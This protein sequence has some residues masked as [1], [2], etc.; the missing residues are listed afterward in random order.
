MYMFNPQISNN[1]IFW[2]GGEVAGLGGEGG[3]GGELKGGGRR[4][5]PWG[6]KSP[7]PTPLYETLNLDITG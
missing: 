3:G 1:F 2:W 4:P 5:G 6:R 7:F